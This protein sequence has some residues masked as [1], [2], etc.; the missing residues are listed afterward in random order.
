MYDAFSLAFGVFSTHLC[1]SGKI[2]RS[3]FASAGPSYSI[4]AEIP[5][6]GFRLNLGQKGGFD[7]TS[8]SHRL[9]MKIDPHSVLA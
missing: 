2:Y 6:G 3:M 1:L 9:G 7:K 4:S 5:P 8:G